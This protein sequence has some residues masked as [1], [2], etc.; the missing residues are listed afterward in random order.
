MRFWSRSSLLQSFLSPLKVGADDLFQCA[1]L[2]LSSHSPQYR[3]SLSNLL[4]GQSKCLGPGR[5]DKSRRT[6][7]MHSESSSVSTAKRDRPSDQT[8]PEEETTSHKLVSQMHHAF[9]EQMPKS[10]SMRHCATGGYW[11]HRHTTLSKQFL[12]SCRQ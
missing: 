6:G 9:I 5:M 2:T 7:A 8:R 11:R 10:Q 1:L 12:L 4:G 3:V